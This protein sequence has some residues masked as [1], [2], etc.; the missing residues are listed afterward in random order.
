MIKP[1]SFIF[2]KDGKLE[3]NKDVID[4]IK[5]SVNPKFIL[6][7]GKT[8]LGKSTTLNQIIRGNHQTWSFKNKKPFNA[9][10]TGESVTK[11]CDIF[12]PIKITEIIKRHEGLNKKIKE[13]FDVFF[14]DTEGISSL[15]GIEKRTIPGILTL[16]QICTISVF[17]INK[18][19]TSND[20]KEIC[21]QIQ[22][23]KIFNNK[24]NNLVTPMVTVYISNILAGEKDDD[25][26]NEENEDEDERVEDILRIRYRF[27]IKLKRNIQI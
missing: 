5:K 21:S 2:E 1:L 11:G 16:L 18:N 17:M 19:C 22:I 7:Y 13:D 27:M 14:C 15:D 10:N 4:I 3:L 26:S 24:K 12:G 9:S 6:F 8:R 25:S 20:L 23:S